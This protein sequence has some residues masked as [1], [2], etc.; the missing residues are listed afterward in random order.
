MLHKL[1]LVLL[2]S[3]HHL[4]LLIYRNE[5]AVILTP[6]DQV[7]AQP[8]LLCCRLERCLL[9]LSQALSE[10]SAKATEALGALLVGPAARPPWVL[11]FSAGCCIIAGLVSLAKRPGAGIQPSAAFRIATACQLIFEVGRPIT[12]VVAAEVEA[13]AAAGQPPDEVTL[14]LLSSLASDQLE[15][16]TG[17]L[18]LLQPKAVTTVGAAFA[19]STARPAVMLP[20]LAEVARAVRSLKDEISAIDSPG[21]Q[22]Y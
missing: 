2:L 10:W 4:P 1:C 11:Q 12:A 16:V 6:H 17:C 21:T 13:D 8:H 22:G 18:S 9:A 15:A 19:R 5:V 3:A 14:G 20:W 7:V